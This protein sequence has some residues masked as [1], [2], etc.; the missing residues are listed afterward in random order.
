METGLHFS[1]QTKY[2]TNKKELCASFNSLTS[3]SSSTVIRPLTVFTHLVQIVPSRPHKTLFC[4]HIYLNVFMCFA[5]FI[6]GRYADLRNLLSEVSVPLNSADNRDFTI[7]II[8]KRQSIREFLCTSNKKSY[9]V[10]LFYYFVRL[11]DQFI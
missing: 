2:L 6:F 7:P 1:I 4:K 8:T 5:L 11:L 9:S 3:I 10:K